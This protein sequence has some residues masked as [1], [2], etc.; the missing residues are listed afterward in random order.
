MEGRKER[1]TLKPKNGKSSDAGF[2]GKTSPQVLIVFLVVRRFCCPAFRSL[3][4]AFYLCGIIACNFLPQSESEGHRQCCC[5]T[6]LH[7]VLQH[8]L[9]GPHVYQRLAMSSAYNCINLLETYREGSFHSSQIFFL[10]LQHK[11]EQAK[12]K[13]LK[14]YTFNGFN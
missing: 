2:G 9:A 4:F 10:L 5:I 14:I 11:S 3:S 13:I 6:A 8:S 12:K 7:R 1:E